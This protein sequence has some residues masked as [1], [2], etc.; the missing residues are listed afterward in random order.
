MREGR[1]RKGG[2][3]SKTLDKSL[4]PGHVETRGAERAKAVAVHPC[5]HPL[6]YT[7]SKCHIRKEHIHL[8]SHKG[9]FA[10]YSSE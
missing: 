10:L 9:C 7:A 6:V 2:R 8:P 4:S 5:T 1:V 3:G